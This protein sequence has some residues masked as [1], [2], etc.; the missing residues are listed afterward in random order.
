M[1]RSEILEEAKKQ[2]CGGREEDY[3]N[4]EDSFSLIANLWSSYLDIKIS[5][6]DVACM[7]ALLKIARIKRGVKIDSSIDLAGYAACIGEIDSEKIQNND[8][9]A[10]TC[11]CRSTIRR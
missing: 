9:N 4:P 8:I 6:K 7:M 5:S 1:R 10:Y 3:G 11:R 2:V